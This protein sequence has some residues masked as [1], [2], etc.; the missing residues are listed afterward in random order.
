MSGKSARGLAQSKALRAA[1]VVADLGV[2]GA[3]QKK[4]FSTR[5]KGWFFDGF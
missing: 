1:E 4:Y 3:L 2:F 5:E